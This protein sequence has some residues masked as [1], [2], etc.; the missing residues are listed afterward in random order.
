MKTKVIL[1]VIGSISV[2]KNDTEISK[3]YTDKI[4]IGKKAFFWT[5]GTM[6]LKIYYSQ[7]LKKPE[8]E[9]NLSTDDNKY[10][11]EYY[12]E[13]KVFK[14]IKD[15]DN[16]KPEIIKEFKKLNITGKIEEWFRENKKKIVIYDTDFQLNQINSTI[17]IG[18]KA[19]ERKIILDF[20]RFSKITKI[21]PA[22]IFYNDMKNYPVSFNSFDMYQKDMRR[23][24]CQMLLMPI[25]N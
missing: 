17:T 4:F 13:K 7:W 14:E 18:I 15:T 25:R 8:V 16:I 6:A 21:M 3:K 12:I 22:T 10:H 11:I 23:L 5:D 1:D 9:V 24:H 2:P 20:E 19:G